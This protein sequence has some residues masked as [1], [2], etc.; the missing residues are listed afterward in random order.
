MTTDIL[1][2]T[3]DEDW[4]EAFDDSALILDKVL[5]LQP[6]GWD[7]DQDAYEVQS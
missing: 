1:P 4:R 2:M 3:T 7:D 5:D 6:A